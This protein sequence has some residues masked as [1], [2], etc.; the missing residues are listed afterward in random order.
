MCVQAW[1]CPSPLAQAARGSAACE[2]G[3]SDASA[4]TDF[5]EA[6]PVSHNQPQESAPMLLTNRPKKKR[7]AD[8][9]WNWLK[10]PH[11]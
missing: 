1:A 6:G 11:S 2:G 5:D 8:K 3:D 10:R 4:G 9:G 7:T